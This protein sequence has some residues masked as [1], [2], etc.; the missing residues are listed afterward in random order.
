MITSNTITELTKALVKFHKEVGKI[1]KDAQNPFFKSGYASLSSVQDAIKDPLT[2]NGL[3]YVQFP[4][5]EHSLT[6]RLMHES[7]E[8]MEDSYSMT[9][10]KNDPQG[11]GSAITYQRRYALGAILGLNIDE[12]DDGNA[13]SAKVAAKPT[14]APSQKKTLD[15]A[16]Y[17][18]KLEAA[19]DADT[20]KKAWASL[21]AEAKKELEKVKETLKK[22]YA[23]N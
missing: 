8:W 15:M 21:P 2:N 19:T 11:V 4:S 14:T 1:K 7:G 13:A 3:A 23:G 18:A 20:L 16:S 5:G 9:P 10:A 22:K 12:D 17:R 6:T